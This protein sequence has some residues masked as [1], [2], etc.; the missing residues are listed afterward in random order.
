[1]LKLTEGLV[2]G[3]EGLEFWERTTKLNLIARHGDLSDAQELFGLYLANPKRE[4]LLEPIRKLG[5]AEIGTELFRRCFDRNDAQMGELIELYHTVGYLGCQEALPRLWEKAS[6]GDYFDC[7]GASL[8]LAHLDCTSIKNEIAEEIRKLKGQ[9]SF[10]EFLPLLA[11]KTEDE[12]FIEELFLW[13]DG[14]TY[15]STA[16]QDCNGGLIVGVALFGDKGKVKFEEILWSPK[17]QTVDSGTGSCFWAYQGMLLLRYR[18]ADLLDQIKRQA[19]NGADDRQ[20]EY[21][22]SVLLK[23]IDIQISS[24]EIA[25]FK[26]APTPLDGWQQMKDF[27]DSDFS[28]ES[29]NLKWGNSLYD[30]VGK[31]FNWTHE[32]MFEIHHLND[33]L[34]L[35]VEQEMERNMLKVTDEDG[36]L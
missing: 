20:I 15:G 34:E 33:L 31:R 26:F 5:N 8:G 9:S 6:K 16:S 32:F 25:R 35:R 22:V 23:L 19:D 4:E 17:W 11:F 21:E 24:S 2:A 18:F 13:G 12:S 28:D 30:F 14:D 36:R 10:N 29:K 3:Y 7:Q 1:M 27:L